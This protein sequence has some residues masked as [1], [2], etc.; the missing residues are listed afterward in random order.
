MRVR[1]TPTRASARTR[2]P[3][4]PNGPVACPTNNSSQRRALRVRRRLLLPEGHA[5]PRHDQRRADD[6]VLGRQPVFRRTGSRTVTWTST[7]LD[8]QCRSP[9]RTAPGTIRPRSS[10]PGRSRPTGKPYPQ[11]QFETNVGGV[12][13]PLR[14]RDRRGLHRRRRIG[15]KF[16]PF[17][18]LSPHVLGARVAPAPGACGTSGTSCRIPSKTF[19]KDAQYGTPNVA[20]FAGTSTSAVHA[21]PEFTGGCQSLADR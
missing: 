19:G 16:Y 13:D 6:G 14:H 1:A 10:T 2:R 9:G 15:S 21:N 4:G 17:W 8:Y 11:I 3:Q 18:S 5:G 12:G 7:A 20:R